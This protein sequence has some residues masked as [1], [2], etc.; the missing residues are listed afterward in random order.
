MI[1]NKVDQN[2]KFR[3]KMKEAANFEAI[4]LRTSKFLQSYVAVDFR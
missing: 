4:F 1:Y 2:E 3:K